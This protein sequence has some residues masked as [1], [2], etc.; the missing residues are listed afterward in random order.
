MYDFLSESSFMTVLT[1]P[2]RGGKRPGIII[3]P[4]SQTHCVYLRHKIDSDL[5]LCPQ[6]DAFP[7]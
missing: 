6:H 1:E 2:T 5:L 4:E 7:G 3:F